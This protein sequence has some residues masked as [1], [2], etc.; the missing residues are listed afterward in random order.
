MNGRVVG[1]G[2]RWFGDDAVGPLVI[3][4]LRRRAVEGLE[5]IEANDPSDLVELVQTGLPV[6][7]VDAAIRVG[8]PARPT[9][10]RVEVLDPR[11]LRPDVGLGL[12]SHGVDVSTALRIAET[13]AGVDGVAPSIELVIVHARAP[14]EGLPRLHPEVEAAIPEAVTRVLER[15][16]SIRGAKDSP[17]GAKSA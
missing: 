14:G 8:G 7:I 6:V 13:L 4:A 1:L 5:L 2:R 16:A 11:T 12:S 9:P 10:G 15:L 17:K 3:D